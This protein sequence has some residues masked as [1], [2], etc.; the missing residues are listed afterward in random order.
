MS[1]RNRDHPL[2][3]IQISSL[4]LL[5]AVIRE[6]VHWVLGRIR[7]QNISS[8]LF[9]DA[10]ISSKIKPRPLLSKYLHNCHDRC[11]LM[12]GRTK[13]GG[14]QP[15]RY[16]WFRAQLGFMIIFHHHRRLRHFC[17]GKKSPLWQKGGLSIKPALSCRTAIIIKKNN[18]DG[19]LRISWHT[20]I[21]GVPDGK[22]IFL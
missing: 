17:G 6:A 9:T 16:S 21:Q 20:P 15:S 18:F 7:G 13:V 11:V 12:T 14:L 10:D 5:E 3:R 2:H 1:S 19:I 22:S 8:F 4:L